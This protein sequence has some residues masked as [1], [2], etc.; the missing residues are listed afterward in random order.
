MEKFLFLLDE[1]PPCKSA[2]GICILKILEEIKKYGEVYCI[3][4]KKGAYY[5]YIKSYTIR[6]KPWTRKVEW[7]KA[8]D[9]NIAVKVMFLVA[10]IIYKMKRLLLLG[11]WPIDSLSTVYEYYKKAS[12]IIAN[13]KI[14]HVIA[15]SYPG[16]T[17]MALKHLKKVYKKEIVTIMYPLDVTLEGLSQ[18]NEIEKY[19]SKIGGRRLLHDC[20]KF[21]D[22]IF[23]LENA[24]KLYR[25]IFS[26]AEQKKFVISGIPMIERKMPIK[27]EKKQ[28][29][30]IHCAYGGNL[31]SDIR[32]P[33]PVL[34]ILED[35]GRKK[36]E[37]IIFDIYG[38]VDG[39]LNTAWK[40]RYSNLKIIQH[41]WVK[42]EELNQALSTADI[43]VNIGNTQS[44]LIPSK[45]FKYMSMG[46]PIL[47]QYVT[48]VDPCIPYLEKYNA[49]LCV[50][51]DDSIEENAKKIENFLEKKESNNTSLE[52]LF[53]RCTPGYV[54]NLIKEK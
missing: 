43:L 13:E 6:Q 30:F 53:P 51:A 19:F 1:L 31:F 22:K 35:I 54:A 10:R 18:G 37:K 4:W 8:H 11:I 2:N 47:H 52:L 27:E 36:T 17:L 41:G 20:L 28:D 49:A 25:S 44:H 34:D 21:A 3:T 42:E 7:F 50:C 16:E 33:T 15:V 9:T 46:K 26:K 14:T 40:G 24:E 38:A 39:K 45:L 12:Q 48:N 23:V 29:S 32:N 5:P